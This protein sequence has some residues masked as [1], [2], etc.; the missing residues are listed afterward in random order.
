MTLGASTMAP[1][2]AAT[3]TPPAVAMNLRRSVV[4]LAS[5]HRYELVVSAFG[6]VIPGTHQRLELREGRVDF[7]GHGSLLGFLP[8]DLGRQ[9]LEIAQN[10]HR[11]LDHLDLALELR[12][13]S[14]QRDRV[15]G[16]EVRAAIGPG[17]RR[18]MVERPLQV[19]RKRLI[20]LLV[21]AELV[22]GTGLVPARVVVEA[23]GIVETELHVVM[24]SDPFAGVDD[25]PL[26]GG[27]DLA[28]WG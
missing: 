13:E 3:T 7:P 5:S 4:T 23:R 27:V 10:R 21:E 19:D 17:R 22:Y 20:R 8:D 24:R 1:A 26:E 2:A 15:L 16:V 11:E 6:D 18:G 9:L 28:A 14:A 12:L 25:A